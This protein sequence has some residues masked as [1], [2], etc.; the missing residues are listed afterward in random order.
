[1]LLAMT[2]PYLADVGGEDASL[3]QALTAEAAVVGAVGVGMETP[4]P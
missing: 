1:M 4:K 2:R 3:P